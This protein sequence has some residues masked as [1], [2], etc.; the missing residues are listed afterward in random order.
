MKKAFC[1][2]IPYSQWNHYEHFIADINNT[3]SENGTVI[4]AV[5]NIPYFLKCKLIIECIDGEGKHY[6]RYHIKRTVGV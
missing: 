3:V 6:Q 2:D 5:S 4:L 1:V